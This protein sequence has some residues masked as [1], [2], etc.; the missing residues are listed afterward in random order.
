MNYRYKYTYERRFGSPLH[1][2]S[3]VGAKG[4]IHLHITDHDAEHE[5]KYGVRYSGGVEEHRRSPPDYKRTDAPDHDECWL[6]KCPCWCDGSSLY[7]TETA[8]PF[9]LVEPH[10]HDRM[11]DWL[12]AEMDARFEGI[13]S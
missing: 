1:I 4:G 7:A 3:A 6:L 5:Q 12:K 13:E 10:N 8:L 2:W 11:F 9:W